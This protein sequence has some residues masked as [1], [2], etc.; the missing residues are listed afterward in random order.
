LRTPAVSHTFESDIERR[1]SLGAQLP[2]GQEWIMTMLAEI[3]LL[4]LE[5][6]MRVAA[7]DRRAASSDPR[8]VPIA[9]PH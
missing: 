3:F 9:L 4:K 7:I 6:L 5:A 8:F 1:R 2:D